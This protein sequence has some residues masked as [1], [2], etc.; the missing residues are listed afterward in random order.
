MCVVFL[1]AFVCL[2]EIHI[3]CFLISVSAFLLNLY[4]SSSKFGHCS[5]EVFGTDVD[6]LIWDYAMIDVSVL[7]VLV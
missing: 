4:Y 3:G 7:F 2:C 6:F 1:C 5:K